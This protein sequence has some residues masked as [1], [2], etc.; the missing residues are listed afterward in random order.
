MNN[1]MSALIMVCL[2]CGEPMLVGYIDDNGHLINPDQ[3]E[4]D[5]I[6]IQ[7]LDL[8][9]FDNQITKFRITNYDN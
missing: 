6:K 5:Q 8:E 4:K 3:V 2:D 7:R 9:D 1:L